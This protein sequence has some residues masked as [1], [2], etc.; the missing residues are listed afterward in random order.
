MIYQISR[1]CFFP[2][3]ALDY[4]RTWNYSEII[5]MLSNATQSFNGIST[6]FLNLIESHVQSFCPNTPH[7]QVEKITTELPVTK[8]IEE[9]I[10][11][12]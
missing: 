3:T 11:K 4:A 5:D 6:S 2:K 8:I 1:K 9:Q 12:F 7:S 10:K